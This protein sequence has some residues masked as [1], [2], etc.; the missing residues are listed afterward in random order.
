MECS[1]A[2][3]LT[4]IVIS[5]DNQLCEWLHCKKRRL[6]YVWGNT[7]AQEWLA[8]QD[9]EFLNQMSNLDQFS[10]TKLPQHTH[11][12]SLYRSGACFY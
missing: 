11:T 7:A 2:L 9:I 3:T 6:A 5:S 12:H 10:D 8:V 4:C 1:L